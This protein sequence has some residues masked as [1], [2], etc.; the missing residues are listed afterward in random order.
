MKKLV[1]A[2]VIASAATACAPVKEYQKA[3]LHDEEMKLTN[4]QLER[5]EQNS[6]IY[7]EGR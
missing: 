1:L 3:F 5:F 4:R 7:R 2:F 6:L